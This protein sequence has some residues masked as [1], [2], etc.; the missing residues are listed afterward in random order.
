MDELSARLNG[1]L[2]QII[3]IQGPYKSDLQ[4]LWS[5]AQ[6][7]NAEISKELVVC[8]RTHKEETPRLADLKIEME[9]ALK[10]V[11]HYLILATLMI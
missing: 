7:V 4:R 10:T 9:E 3:K 8:R 2:T 5:N 11:D 6:R 1:L